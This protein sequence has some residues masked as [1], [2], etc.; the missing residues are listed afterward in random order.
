MKEIHNL[1]DCII[2]ERGNLI[3]QMFKESK[4]WV[5][6][7][8]R[9]V[10]KDGQ[11]VGRYPQTYKDKDSLMKALEKRDAQ[12]QVDAGVKPH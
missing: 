2:Y 11:V 4:R 7:V 9:N 12:E 10:A 1:P 5:M 6:W 8:P 3:L